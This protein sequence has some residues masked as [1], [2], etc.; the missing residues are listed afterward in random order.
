MNEGYVKKINEE[1]YV[2]NKTEELYEFLSKYESIEPLEL[3]SL[4]KKEFK[5]NHQ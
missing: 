2:L 3:E 1:T 5:T 4:K